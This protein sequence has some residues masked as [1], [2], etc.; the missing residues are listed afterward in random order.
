MGISDHKTHHGPDSGD[1]TT[2]PYIIY[3][4]TL[5]RTY[6]QVALFPETPKLES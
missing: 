1:A 4:A 3:Y 5:R 2:I 6:I